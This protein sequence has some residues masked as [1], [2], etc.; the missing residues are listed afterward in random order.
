[1]SSFAFLL[2][3]EEMGFPWLLGDPYGRPRQLQHSVMILFVV[4]LT[5]FFVCTNIS[6]IPIKDLVN[7]SLNHFANLKRFYFSMLVGGLQQ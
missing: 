5:G 4:L 3:C 1:M 6:C 2:F 7:Y